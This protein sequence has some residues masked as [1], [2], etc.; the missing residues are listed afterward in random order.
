MRPT[1]HCV[2][3][4]QGFH[5]VGGGNYSLPDPSLTPLGEQQCESLRTNSFAD[6]TKISLVAASP[7]RRTLHTASLVFGE[8]LESHESCSPTILAF[9]DAQEISDD[10]CDTGSDPAVL[11]EV[12]AK[13][14][15]P[16]DLSLVHEGWNS[17]SLE[18][19][20][21]PRDSAIRARAHAVRLVLRQ[22]MRELIKKG[23]PA[24]QI[25]LVTHGGFLHYL[26]DDW[27]E[28]DVYAGTG[29]RN[30]ETR[31]YEFK[32][33][34]MQ[35][36]DLEAK[37]VET[38][39]SRLKRGKMYPVIDQAEQNKLSKLSMQRWEAQGLQRF[40]RI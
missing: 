40:D 32:E 15:W 18:G 14:A 39:E 12:A 13:N 23:N 2:R 28:S 38:M 37:L 25:V 26:T 31:S 9:P 29:W 20:Y 11:R 21:S 6:Q 30:C 35:Y 22:E 19:P 8:A 3:H 33:D 34:C 27:E 4:A 7:L 17:K 5:N 36:A 10:L 24:P 1:I 16:L